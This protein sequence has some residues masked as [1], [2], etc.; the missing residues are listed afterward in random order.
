[1]G[2]LINKITGADKAAKRAAEAQRQAADMAKYRPWDLI[3]SWYGD[4]TFDDAS[5]TID[6]SLS[7]ELQKFRDYFYN[8]AL[9]F[10]PTTAQ[11]QL[12]S[13][14][15]QTGE[16]IFRR[17][18]T[19]DLT[20]ATKDYYNQQLNLLAPER[21]AE[22]VR[23]NEQLYGTGRGGLGVSVGTGGY[24]NPEQ[25]SRNLA[26]EQINAEI[27]ANA[28]D[29][30]RTL[31]Q[32]DI[33]LGTGL[34]GLGQQ[35]RLQ[36]ITQSGSLLD[37]A[38]GVEQMGMTPMNLGLQVGSAAQP[39]NTAMASGYMNAANTRFMGDMSGATLF[40][41]LMG[42]AASMIPWSNVGSSIGGM[43]SNLGIGGGGYSP[44]RGGAAPNM[45]YI[46]R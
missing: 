30:A 8:Q 36:P 42:T 34:F 12:F 25:Y 22:D 23:L 16:D 40:S 39:G 7:P 19:T 31:Q 3:G 33:N 46:Q 14:I 4:V 15:S 2:S 27:L 28:E 18:A 45:S 10:Q 9:G 1:M 29:R 44:I 6:Y 21:A 20:K 17:G 26:R 11:N 37:M 38:S 32:Q 43:F 35:M 24:I 5:R 41:D 13:D